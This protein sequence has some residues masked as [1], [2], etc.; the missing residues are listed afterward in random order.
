MGAGPVTETYAGFVPSRVD[1]EWKGQDRLL[2]ALTALRQ[3]RADCSVHLIFS[4]WGN[5]LQRARDFARANG[6]A[7]HV[8]FL[9][10]GLS[11]PLLLEFFRAADFVVDQFIVGMTG[12]SALEAMACAAPVMMWVNDAVERHWGQPPVIQARTA[13]DIER[14]LE[15]ISLARLDLDEIGRRQQQWVLSQH[16]P[17]KVVRGLREVFSQAVAA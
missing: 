9:D 8:T 2:R 17:A 5:D 1:F 12:T 4:G 3:R 13:E 11:K 6:L 15:D 16:D 7:Q 10:A 14:A